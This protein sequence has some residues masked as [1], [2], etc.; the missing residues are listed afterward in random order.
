MCSLF[1]LGRQSGFSDGAAEAPAGPLGMGLAARMMEKM[2]WKEG[3][4]LGR[5]QQG[6]ATP[7]IAKKTDQ[8]SGRIVVADALPAA[9][10]GPPEKRLKVHIM[11]L[12]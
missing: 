7:L 10:S 8:R 11:A 9:D 2:G 3:Q 12:Y 4:G 1:R 5:N 6:I